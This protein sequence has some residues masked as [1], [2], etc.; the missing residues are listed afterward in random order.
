MERAA[1]LEIHGLV[2]IVALIIVAVGL[3]HEQQL[4]APLPPQAYAV[5]DLLLPG[6]VRQ[7][8]FRVPTRVEDVRRFYQRALSSQ[9]W[10]SVRSH[11]SVTLD[12]AR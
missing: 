11:A 2:L 6:A 1:K 12:A 5:D 7:S 4:R 8:W 9:G 3:R 10:C